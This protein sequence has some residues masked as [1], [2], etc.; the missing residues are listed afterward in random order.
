MM[1]GCRRDPPGS[2]G[3]S[4]MAVFLV[5]VSR[6]ILMMRGSRGGLFPRSRP[7]FPLTGGKPV[8]GA[9]VPAAGE[10]GHRA[11]LQERQQLEDGEEGLGPP[12]E[13]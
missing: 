12:G 11:H 9:L 5:A 2:I 6:G 7:Q 4:T 8:A 1:L 13:R 3:L 10:P